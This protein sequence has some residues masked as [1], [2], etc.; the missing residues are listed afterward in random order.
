[1]TRTLSADGNNDIFLGPDGALAVA[2]QLD[3]VMQ[4][5]QQ[6]AQTQLGEMMYAVDQGIPNFATIWNGAR[7]IS[8]FDA[9]LRRAI[10]AVEH[11]T[12]ISNLT[13]TTSANTL[14][15]EATIQTDFGAGAIN[16]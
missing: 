10:L 15:Y 16:G 4:A 14:S 8:Q 12:G 9:Y 3:A 5:A 13:I 1:M 2:S 11:V 7:N 6:A